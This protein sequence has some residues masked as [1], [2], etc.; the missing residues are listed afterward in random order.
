MKKIHTLAAAALML[1]MAACN[2][3]RR[4]IENTARCYLDAMGNYRIDDAIPYST[5][6]TRQ[7]TLPLAKKLTEHCDPAYIQSNTPA[8]ITIRGSR[9]LTDT[10]AR[11]YYHKHTPITEQ[12]D[13]L[14]LFL[15]DGQWLVDVRFGPLPAALPAVLADSMPPRLKHGTVGLD[16]DSVFLGGKYRAMKDIQ[17]KIKHFNEVPRR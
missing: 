10:S 4:Q 6:Y 11:V 14:T 7:N 17:G 1:T 15:E 3:D 13:S 2:S 12:E 8:E 16:E 5:A 9:Q